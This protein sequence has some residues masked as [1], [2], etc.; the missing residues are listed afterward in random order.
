[1]DKR[2]SIFVGGTLVLLGI[3]SLLFTGVASLFGINLLGL[4]L[5]LWPL[6]I[7]CVGL[8]FVAPPLLIRG[9]RG[10]GAL[11]IPGV[12]ILVTSG[13]LFLASVFNVWGVWAW[14]WPMEV[15][16]VAL[17]FF[18]AALY[19]RVIWLLIPGIIIGLNGLVFQFCAVTGLWSWWS[20]LWIIEPLSVGLALLLIGARRQ[21]SGLTRAG[22]ILCGVSGGGFALMTLILGGWPARL[23]GAGILILAGVAVLIWGTVR[24]RLLAK[25][26]LE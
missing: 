6:T 17:G 15:L 3:L 26:A 8:L 19:M 5:R 11:F 22:L 18:A 23:L 25:S 9:R 7:G 10:L 16:G 4:V 14:L 21:N 20:V 13:I 2:S 12:P 24:P 1:M